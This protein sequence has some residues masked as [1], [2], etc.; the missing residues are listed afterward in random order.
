[1]GLFQSAETASHKAQDYNSAPACTRLRQKPMKAASADLAKGWRPWLS[2]RAPRPSFMGVG[3][4]FPIF[5]CGKNAP[6][7]AT[8][9]RPPGQVIP[10][11]AFSP[12]ANSST[13]R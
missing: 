11:L 2:R 5:R 9:G 1:M 7:K 4:G 8:C 12:D 13:L 6:A 10:S 3:Y